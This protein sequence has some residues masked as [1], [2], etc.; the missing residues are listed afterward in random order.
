MAQKAKEVAI[1]F[2]SHINL[3]KGKKIPKNSRQTTMVIALGAV[4]RKMKKELKAGS[5]LKQCLKVMRQPHNPAT[6]EPMSNSM[7]QVEDEDN[8]IEVDQSPS[9]AMIVETNHDPT[10]EGMQE[11]KAVIEVM[12]ESSSD[13]DDESTEIARK[14]T[15]VNQTSVNRCFK[16][17]LPKKRLKNNFS[18]RRLSPRNKRKKM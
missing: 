14:Q 2:N 9:V 15:S 10:S 12:D 3:K 8:N 6:E 5:S 16:P 18:A 13:E 11:N 1:E 4:A 17:K 7:E